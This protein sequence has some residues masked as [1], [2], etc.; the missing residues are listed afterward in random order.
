MEVVVGLLVHLGPEVL[1]ETGM[2]G[3]RVETVGDGNPTL[4]RRPQAASV[5]TQK[6]P[7]MDT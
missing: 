5:D 4:W 7:L 2:P 6:R 3:A 1:R